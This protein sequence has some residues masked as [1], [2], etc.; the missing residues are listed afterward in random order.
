MAL[1]LPA[2]PGGLTLPQI[3]PVPITRIPCGCEYWTDQVAGVWRFVF[4]PHA[5]DCPYWLYTWAE[6]ERQGKP[7]VVVEGV[8]R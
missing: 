6:S 5:W 3:N 2:A 7:I 1:P 8:A 4:R